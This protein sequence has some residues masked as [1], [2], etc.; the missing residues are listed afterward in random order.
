M[1]KLLLLLL[2]VVLLASVTGCQPESSQEYPVKIAGYT[3]SEK[4]SVIVCLSDSVADILIAC[5]YAD[6][7]AARSDEC[8]Q[9]EI[10]SV[11]SVGSKEQPNIQKIK[12]LHPQIVFSDKLL[13]EDSYQKLSQ[14]TT[15]L[16]M[17]PASTN[18]DL[19]RLYSNICAIVDGNATG[20][21]NGEEKAHSILITMDDLQRV[22]PESDIVQ[23]ACYLYD[24][25]G[26]AATDSNF[27]GKLFSY[28]NTTNICASVT[29]NDDTIEKIRLSNP[30]YIFCAVGV[31]DQLSADN[32]F[33]NLKAVKND[34]VFE[35]DSLLL[36]RQGNSLTEV[37]SFMI[38][39]MYPEL[40]SGAVV[41]HVDEVSRVSPQ[42]Q[43]SDDQESSEKKEESETEESSE[44]SDAS[45]ESKPSDS[46]GDQESS[47][48]SKVSAD[49]SLK[50]TENLSYGVGDSGDDI[51]KIQNR[52]KD[53][54][55]FNDVATGYFGELSAEAFR[56]FEEANSLD[57]DGYAS[58]EDLVLLFSADVRPAS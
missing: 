52:L 3:F 11:N 8:T 30:D 23:T 16:T 19:V 39:M 37:L 21:Q 5:G 38:E 31:K 44:P 18:D 17:M 13:N 22:I 2:T 10:A 26:D 47:E 43:S 42:K 46:S 54:G 15:V 12:E 33:K 20:R 6:R 50:I 27:D 24:S 28:A 57:V 49:T 35:I 34:R 48:S 56:K 55:F 53:L 29:G 32:N 58:N 1:K 36:N 25:N 7:I 4:P 51:T 41:V 9:P 45:E 40:K 14:E